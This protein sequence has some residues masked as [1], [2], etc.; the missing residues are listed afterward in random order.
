[1]FT[2]G[3]QKGNEEEG[4]SIERKE[5]KGRKGAGTALEYLTSVDD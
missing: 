4:H 3:L 1:V 5:M 2:F